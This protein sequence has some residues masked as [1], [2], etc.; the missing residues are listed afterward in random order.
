MSDQFAELY[1]RLHE[2]PRAVR[3]A[4]H[5]AIGIILFLIW[6]TYLG[7]IQR[8]WSA[9]ADEIET[10]VSELRSADYEDRIRRLRSAIQAHGPLK[11]PAGE[12]EATEEMS[13]V[14]NEVMNEYRSVVNDSF[15][16]AVR[17]ALPKN[18]VPD[19]TQGRQRIS[20]LVGELQFDADARDVFEIIAHLESRPE[21][22]S[23]ISLTLQRLPD[24]GMNVRLEIESWI[25]TRDTSSGRGR[26]GQV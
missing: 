11:L 22:E 25:K 18:A 24:Q 15:S 14:V 5:A 16:L 9:A 10:N 19:L 26:G 7:P 23:I 21:I 17:G 12:A 1:H 13:R 20:R 8:S 6:D 4:I 2:L 3:W